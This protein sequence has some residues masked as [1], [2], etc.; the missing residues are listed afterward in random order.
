MDQTEKT[1][2]AQQEPPNP[3]TIGPLPLCH[4]E[5]GLAL[6]WEVF[7]DCM[8]E[9]LSE[10]GLDEFWASIDYEYMLQRVGDG[11]LRFWG[12]FD[13]DYLVGVCALRELRHI[14]L[15]Y[16]DREYQCQGV[17]TNL[18]KHAALDA[19]QLDESVTRMTVNAAAGSQGFFEKQ[20]FSQTGPAQKDGGLTWLPMALEGNC[21]A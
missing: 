4:L 14:E 17:A 3:K 18:L 2:P 21:P 12:A 9:D 11:D 8:A 5:D 1:T 20:G 10:E 16:V 13:G 15:L 19:R 6:V 7:S